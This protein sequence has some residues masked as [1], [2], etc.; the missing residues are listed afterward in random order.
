[1]DS[2]ERIKNIFALKPA[3]RCGFWMGNP[4][5]DTWPLLYKAFGTEDREQIRVMMGDD[6]RWIAEHG[7]SYK[8]PE[9]KPMF[10]MQRKGEELSAAGYFSDCESV[11]EV[12]DF[13]WPSVEYLDL[14]PM[15]TTLKNTGP[16]YRA[17]GFWSP[18][19]HLVG[20]FFGM[21]NYFIKMYTHPEVVHAVTKHVVDFFLDANKLLFEKAGDEID[22]FFF[23]NDFGTQLDILVGPEQF[24]EFIFPYF[25]KLTKLGHD[26]GYQVILHSCGSIYRVIENLIELG[27]DALHPLQAKAANMDAERLA[28]EFGGRIAFMGGID[29]QQ[30]LDHGTPEE[31]AAEVERIKKVLG[32]N[33]VISPSHECILPNVPIENVKAMSRAALK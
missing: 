8:H 6:L 13:D 1:M 22:G 26:Y 5:E 9:G 25:K 10:D 21:E 16:Y 31:V 20:D 19:F 28:R 12:E 4:H 30:L 24:N 23:G 11:A 17:S 7:Q 33:V 14:E 32:P 27:V 2:R 29:T 15:L 3:D 18:F